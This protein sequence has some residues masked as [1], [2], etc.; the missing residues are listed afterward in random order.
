MPSIVDR[1][2]RRLLS[3]SPSCARSFHTCPR[4]G[5]GF[6]MDDLYIIAWNPLV[7][8]ISGV[9]SAFAE[10]LLA[11][12]RWVVRCTRPLPLASFALTVGSC[13]GS[14]AAVSRDESGVARRGGR[15]CHG[16]GLRTPSPEGRRSERTRALLLD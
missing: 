11:A 8:S 7:H 14:S 3:R 15:R 6:A 1:N 2:D 13:R 5:D 12:R 4:C 10:T 16:T 9:F